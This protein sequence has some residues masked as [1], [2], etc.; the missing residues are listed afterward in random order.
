MDL[1]EIRNQ[2]RERMRGFCAV[3]KECDG[4]N[5]RGEV[6]GMGGTLSGESFM[7]NV[8]ALKKIKLNLR[9][10]HNVKDPDTSFELFGQKINLPVITAPV[11]GTTF[12]F[13]GYLNEDEYNEAVVVGSMNAGTPAMTGDTANPELF[14]K[15]LHAI[16]KASGIGIPIIKP[17]DPNV[18]IE[19][20][21]EAEK[22]SPLA[23]GMD[24]DGAGLITMKKSPT[25]VYPKTEEELKKI[26]DSTKLP[27]ILKG[28]MTVEDALLAEKCGAKAIVVSNHGGRI[29]DSTPGTAEV[30]PEIAK[31]VKGKMIVMVDGGIRS[32]NDVFKMLA[33]GA[34]CVLIGR[35][36]IVAATGGGKEGVQI[37]LEAYK[38]QLYQT[39]LLTGANNLKEITDEKIAVK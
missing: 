7:E 11:T 8:R 2:A 18:V 34:D 27:F 29:L 5:C 3:C 15:G 28:V 38:N 35:P 30:L 24:I 32:G 4:F 16:E 1:K 17:K 6:P 26:I 33:L 14:L 19:L 10:I 22:Y 12:N 37:Q 23:V 9:T 13:G 36:L 31:A 39:M 20:I 25:P 21:K